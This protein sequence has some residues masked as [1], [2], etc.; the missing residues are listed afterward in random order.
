MFTVE[1]GE[2]RLSQREAVL[3]EDSRSDVTPEL[4]GMEVP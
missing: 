1:S 2:G 3:I 4:L